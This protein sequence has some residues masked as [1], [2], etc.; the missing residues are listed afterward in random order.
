MTHHETG[1][2]IT[3]VLISVSDKDGIVEFAQQLKKLDV[4]ILSTGGTAKLLMSHG[5]SVIEVADYTGFP[6]LMDGRVKTLH[7]KIYAGIL[8]RGSKD[9][10]TLQTHD[11]NPIDLVVVNLYPFQTVTQ[12]PNCKFDEAIENIDIGGPCMIRAAAKNHDH[13]GVI[14]DKN[15]YPKIISELLTYDKK[16]SLATRQDLAK[17]A[18]THTALYDIAISRYLS[19]TT[20]EIFPENYLLSCQK[21]Y[22][23]RYGENPHQQSALYSQEPDSPGTLAHASLL[24]GKPL[25]YNNLADADAALTCVQSFHEQPTCVIV[26]HANPCGIAISDTLC[27]A[28]QRAYATDSTS[29]FGGVIAFNQE[30]DEIT[31]QT[32]LQQQFVEVIV[33]PTIS[34]TALMVLADKPN[35]RVLACGVATPAKHKPLHFKNIS[36]GLLIQEADIKIFADDTPL[37]LVTKLAPT[38]QQLQDLK[39]AWQVVKFVKSNAIVLAKDQATIGLGAGQP[40]RIMSC[41]IA[42]MKAAEAHLPIVQCVMASDAFFPFSDSID[43]AAKMGIKAI[44]QPGGSL[45]DE[46]VIT[47]ANDAK[48]A[49]IFTGIRHFYH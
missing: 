6:E 24:Q 15:D 45:R 33:A 46:E 14:V 20:Q 22:D 27:G 11:I 37:S 26:K 9:Q 2:P 7:P 13:V 43:F 4:E 5:V 19:A 35:I 31:A 17:K 39:F 18:F 8:A 38:E 29:A 1:K 12:N 40:S 25:S 42:A 16:L 41:Q 48:I 47:A 23:L 32:I 44:I 49:M 28:Y 30:L 36:G 34:K 10:Q 21:K 3:R